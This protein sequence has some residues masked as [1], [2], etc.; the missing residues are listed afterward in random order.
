MAQS[1]TSFST[2]VERSMCL[3]QTT[4]AWC[5]CCKKYQPVEQ[6]RR[7]KNLPNAI[8][9]NCGLDSPQVCLREFL[10]KTFASYLHIL[11]FVFSLKK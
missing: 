3:E 7:Y 9:M 10:M 1:G 4:Q 2:I 11:N 6:F 5:E 8:A